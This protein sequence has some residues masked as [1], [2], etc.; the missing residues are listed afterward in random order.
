[1]HVTDGEKFIITNLLLAL[2]Q[3]ERICWQSFHFQF[4]CRCLWRLHCKGFNP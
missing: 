4:S 2:T 3:P 1:M